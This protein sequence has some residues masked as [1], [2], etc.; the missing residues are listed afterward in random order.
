[1][2]QW[3]GTYWAWILAHQGWN[4]S[5][6]ALEPGNMC[7][8]SLVLTPHLLVI[9]PTWQESCYTELRSFC[10]THCLKIFLAYPAWWLSYSM[11]ALVLSLGMTQ[12]WSYWDPNSLDEPLTWSGMFPGRVDEDLYTITWDSS[13]SPPP[14]SHPQQCTV[15][16]EDTG[17]R[18]L[19]E[20]TAH[21]S[22]SHPR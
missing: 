21:T 11:D 18:G 3:V 13:L 17:D 6:V 10:S 9:I 12:P 19:T 1:M 4:P 5:S 7:S 2:N 22:I 8:T 16:L 15:L 20:G 14:M